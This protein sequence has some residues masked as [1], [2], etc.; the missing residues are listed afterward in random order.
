[1]NPKLKKKREKA[2]DGT[3]LFTEFELKAIYEKLNKVKGKKHQDGS[4][5]K[6]SK[7]FNLYCYQAVDIL[8]SKNNVRLKIFNKR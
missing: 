4:I 6:S 7:N 3:P 1:M 2:D 5:L 8:C